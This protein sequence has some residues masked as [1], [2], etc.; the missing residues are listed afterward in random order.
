MPRFEIEATNNSEQGSPE[1]TNASGSYAKMSRQELLQMAQMRESINAR[2]MEA[3]G[4]VGV[5]MALPLAVEAGTIGVLRIAAMTQLE[6]RA[7]FLM[8]DVSLSVINGMDGR[9][10]ALRDAAGFIIPQVRTLKGRMTVFP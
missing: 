2:Q 3:I 5:L 6:K 1:V 7:L 8:A 4:T 10:L 9:P